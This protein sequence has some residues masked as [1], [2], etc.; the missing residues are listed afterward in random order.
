MKAELIF[1]YP[2]VYLFIATGIITIFFTF[3]GLYNKAE[4]I[5]SPIKGFVI[6]ALVHEETFTENDTE[7][8]EYT[9]QAILGIISVNVIWEVS[10]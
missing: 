8:T 9:L 10:G 6:G 2:M 5:I 1:N 3:V 7:I 4:I